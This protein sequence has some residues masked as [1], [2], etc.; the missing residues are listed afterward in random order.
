ME[1][2]SI[3]RVFTTAV[4]PALR[5]G[6]GFI[7]STLEDIISSLVL[8]LAITGSEDISIGKELV[9]T[10]T[11][12]DAIADGEASTIGED[13]STGIICVVS[14]AGATVDVGI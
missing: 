13:C 9:A 8:E 6:D 7:F 5:L 12:F 11:G 1:P 14:G 3:T 4:P 10:M 2:L